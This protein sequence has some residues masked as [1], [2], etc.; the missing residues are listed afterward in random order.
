MMT[1]PELGN[2]VEPESLQ[3][4]RESLR[5]EQKM[6][7][8]TIAMLQDGILRWEARNNEIYAEIDAIDAMKDRQWDDRLAGEAV[9]K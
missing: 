7:Q 6:V 5:V 8:K 2:R 3:R 9:A 1:Q 4:M